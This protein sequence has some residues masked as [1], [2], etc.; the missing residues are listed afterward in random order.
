[1][2]DARLRTDDDDDGVRVLVVDDDPTIAETVRR[3]QAA[4]G[5]AVAVCADGDEGFA[6]ALTGHYDL[7][8]LDIMMPGR[9]GFAVIRDLR[10]AEIWTPV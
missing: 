6:D 9:N 10:R 2:P 4:Q 1:M 7:I 5:W 3:T 8:V